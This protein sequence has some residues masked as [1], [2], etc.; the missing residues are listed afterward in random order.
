MNFLVPGNENV[1]TIEINAYLAMVKVLYRSDLSR[2][3][4]EKIVGSE[5]RVCFMCMEKDLSDC[6]RKVIPD[7]LDQLGLTGRDQSSNRRVG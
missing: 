2:S 7:T 4:R 1:R 3:E 6:R 5:Q